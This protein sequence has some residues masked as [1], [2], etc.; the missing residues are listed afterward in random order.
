MVIS[1]LKFCE[2]ELNEILLFFEGGDYI[3]IRH[4]F[5]EKENK[6]VNTIVIDGKKS[7]AY[8]NLFKKID[9]EIEYKR[10]IKRYAKLSLYKALSTYTG[11]SLPWG[12]LSGVRPTKMAYQSIL[13]RGEFVEFF[14][15]TMKVDPKKTLLIQKI[16]ENQR[17]FYPVDKIYT[18]LYISIPFCPTRCRYCSFI[19]HDLKSAKN[20]VDEYIDALIKEINDA[21]KHVKNLRSIY[22]GGGTPVSLSDDRLERILKAIDQINTGVEYTVEAGRP[23][24]ITESNLKLLEKYKVNRICINP[25]TFNDKTLVKIGRNHTSQDIIDKFNLAKGRFII[26]MDLIAGLDGESYEDF[27][28]SIDKAV[29]LSPDNITVHTLSVKKGSYLAEEGKILSVKEI[30]DMVDYAHKTLD[31]NGY[32][33]YYVYRQKYMAGSLENTG[34][35]KGDTIC[36]Y[37]VGVME[38]I[39]RNLSCGAGA[40]SKEVDLTA[41]KIERLPAPKDLRSYIDKI[42][43]IIEEKNSFFR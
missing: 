1:D 8:G 33:P 18:D 36:A 40:I 10:L 26:N 28:Y 6:I 15:D 7:Y 3:K 9:D 22:V 39:S 31:E 41:E 43:T 13:E 20:L 4:L 27:K 21:K 17:N 32:S 23:D 37:N 14:T 35:F 34:Y 42:D 29:S 12:A 2:H 11:Q 24:K 25:Q 30:N 16:I 38:E 5:A 19:S